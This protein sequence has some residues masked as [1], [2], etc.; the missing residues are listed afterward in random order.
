MPGMS[1]LAVC[2][3]LKGD[4]K[5]ERIP[6]IV[7]T[8]AG[9]REDKIRSLEIGAEEFLRKPVDR[10]ELMA[11]IGSILRTKHLGDRLH[12]SYMELDRLGTFAETIAGPGVGEW[13]SEEV[14]INMARHYLEEGPE[15]SDRPSLTWGGYLVQ[16]TL[17]GL[18][19]FNRSGNGYKFLTKFPPEKLREV[20]EPFR[21]GE[22]SYLSNDPPPDEVRKLLRVPPAL[23]LSNFVSAELGSHFILAAGYPE[24]VDAYEIPLLRSMLR[25]W[26]VFER[27][28][29]ETRQTEKAF[30]YTMEALSLAAE[31]HDPNTA[32]HIRRVNSLAGILST[33]L[34]CDP[35]FV[36]WISRCAQMHDVGKITVPLTILR[37]ASRLNDDEF[38]VMKKHTLNG[39]TILGDSRHL[40]MARQIARSHHENFDGT[41]Y[42]DS[43]RGEQIPL[44]ARIVRI[45]DIYDALRTKRP[46][47]LA[48]PHERAVQILRRGDD[49]TQPE[50]LDPRI[51]EAFLDLQERMDTLYR[52]QPIPEE[53]V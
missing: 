53:S 49:R 46:Y 10:E 32:H 23:E 5:T 39:A 34:G 6:I 51:L 7:L 11:R 45:V 16:R 19:Y 38:S 29:A 52:D 14:A 26:V 8:G 2:Q 48:L 25:H 1:G 22:G 28:R 36:R 3:A 42:P 9:S 44:E 13:R 15:I 4:R 20:L 30:F 40:E 27:I 24:R 18:T 21:T 47:K 41:G 12:R 33:H 43:L 31:L 35:R 50:N 37:K 17:L